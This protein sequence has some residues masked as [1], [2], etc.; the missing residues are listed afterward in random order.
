MICPVFVEVS[1]PKLS[2][3]K[4]GGKKNVDDVYSED[5]EEPTKSKGKK[6]LF[7]SDMS[8]DSDFVAPKKKSKRFKSAVLDVKVSSSDSEEDS[9]PKKGK[10]KK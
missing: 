9:K 4:K 10:G 2:T 5:S 1:F 8:D 6:T 3:P 7:D